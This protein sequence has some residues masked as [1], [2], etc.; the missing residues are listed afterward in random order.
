VQ[1]VWVG[2]VGHTVVFQGFLCNCFF[3]IAFQICFDGGVARMRFSTPLMMFSRWYHDWLERDRKRKLFQ[4]LGGA[5]IEIGA[6]TG[7][8]FS[9]YP[10]RVSSLHV[11]EPDVSLHRR[12]LKRAMSCW[13]SFQIFSDGAE[14][15]VCED[16]SVDFVVGT[17]VL[18]HVHDVDGVLREILRVLKP[19]GRFV[20]L[21]HVVA[22]PGT[23]LHQTQFWIRSPWYWLTGGCSPCRDIESSIRHTGFSTVNCLP[24]NQGWT[25]PITRPRICGYAIK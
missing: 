1:G 17:F 7:V 24:Y 12:L 15:M 6:G 8:N 9:R 11:I 25:F 21:E 19:G 2:F 5:G 13:Y 3:S 4:D 14:S 16:N 22:M 10:T 18:C 23:V 20:F